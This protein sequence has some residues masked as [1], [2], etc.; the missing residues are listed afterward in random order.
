MFFYALPR[1]FTETLKNVSLAAENGEIFVFL[2]RAADGVPATNEQT[3]K[4]RP[5]RL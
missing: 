5:E 1:S 3:K 2:R 4:V